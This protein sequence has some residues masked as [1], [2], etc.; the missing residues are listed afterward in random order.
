MS[1]APLI[2]SPLASHISR[3]FRHKITRP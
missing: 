2:L 3:R 1:Q